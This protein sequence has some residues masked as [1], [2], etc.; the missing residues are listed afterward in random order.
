M[1]AGSQGGVRARRLGM[2]DVMAR[3]LS[4]EAEI[5]SSGDLAAYQVYADWLIER[6]DPRGDLI[7]LDIAHERDPHNS[8][9]S[10]AREALLRV[11]A[12]AW[13]GELARGGGAACTWQRGFLHAVTIKQ[14]D[15]TRH[16]RSYAALC[17]LPTAALL[18]ELAFA[19]GETEEPCWQSAIQALA[20]HGIPASLRGLAF[21]TPHGGYRSGTATL[22]SFASLYPHAGALERLR[23]TADEL[24]LH[25][26]RLPAV[27]AFEVS[28]DGFT[29]A[30]LASVI[31]AAWPRLED[32]ALR[33]GSADIVV[34][35]LV[36]LL[37]AVPPTLRCL[38][39]DLRSHADDYDPVLDDFVIELARSP[40]VR[41]LTTLD[42]SSSL[43][44]DT[45]AERMLRKASAFVHLDCL[46]LSDTDVSLA[47]VRRLRE[48]FG[49]VV[50]SWNGR[51]F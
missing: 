14:T 26:I 48:A 31:E 8:E 2:T 3:N 7:A 18:R 27:R 5:A 4:L 19:G 13:L 29:R 10:Y 47:M 9:L 38:R 20:E 40:L 49:H 36:R 24:D 6:G 33:F 45:L 30:N 15:E 1:S 34:R 35:D 25:D 39:L 11:H 41:R 21:D 23:I 43:F 42:L 16:A 32:L 28:S 51:P 22:G 44:G 17:G 37:D 46:D 50:A 12:D